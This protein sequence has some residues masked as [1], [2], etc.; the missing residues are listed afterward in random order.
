MQVC[1]V[2]AGNTADS[3]SGIPFRPSVTAIR[4]SATPRV[5]RDNDPQR[6]VFGQH[7]LATGAVA[8]VA[9]L[10]GFLGAGRVTQMVAEFCA[11]DAFD[12]CFLEGYR[13]GIDRLGIHR[14]IDHLVNEF[15]GNAG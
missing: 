12:K 14:V 10:A 9:D 7:G 13:G 5:A 1:S 4:M 2:V 11:Q 6:P 3:A 8:V 15:F